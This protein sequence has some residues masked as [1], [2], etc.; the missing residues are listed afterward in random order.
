M[1]LLKH[2]PIHY[3]GELHDVRLIN[4]SVEPDEIR[5]VV[6]SQI[7]IRTFD[8]RAMISMVDVK[9][10]RMHP[11]FVP[12]M[13]HFNYRHIAFRLLVD[14]SHLNNGIAKGIYF[15]RSFTDKP[16]IAI[17]GSWFTDYNLNT[18]TIVDQDNEVRITK[19]DDVVTYS[20]DNTMEYNLSPHLHDTIGALDRAY[21]TDGTTTRMTEIQRE[22]WPIQPMGCTRFR[23]TF[24]KTARFE[25]A[26][27][28]P[29]TIYYDWLPPK[30]VSL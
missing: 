10:R 19:G 3:K 20:I 27:R 1:K 13:L 2:I 6:P 25:G 7:R 30:P 28:V 9:L 24:F 12:S 26:F 17:G 21:S 5:H 8:G 16:L 18:A 11:I 22:K 29:E 14:D 23:T 4:F 15:L